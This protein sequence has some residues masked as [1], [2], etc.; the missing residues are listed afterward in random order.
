MEKEWTIMNNV[1]IYLLLG[2]GFWIGMGFVIGFFSTI[3]ISII[4]GAIAG[5][6]LKLTGRI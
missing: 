5:L 2:I 3:M 6:Y 4:G 1:W